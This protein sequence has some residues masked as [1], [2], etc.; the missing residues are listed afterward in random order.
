M[1]AGTAALLGGL[2]DT[3]RG[4]G[5]LTAVDDREPGGVRSRLEGNRASDADHLEHRPADQ[6]LGGS[7]LL[8]RRLAID[9]DAD[10]HLVGTARGPLDLDRDRGRARLSHQ[11]SYPVHVDECSA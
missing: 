6:L 10:R 8:V 5:L 3:G 2:S 11:G 4:Y 9:G 1:L 7:R